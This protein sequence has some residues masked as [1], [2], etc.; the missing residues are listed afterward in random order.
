MIDEKIGKSEFEFTS[1]FFVEKVWNGTKYHP[2]H[3]AVEDYYVKSLKKTVTDEVHKVIMKEAG[4]LL[5]VIIKGVF[6]MRAN[7]CFVQ[8]K[9]NVG[10]NRHMTSK[11]TKL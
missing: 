11:Y 8:T 1:S 5:G 7:E 3:Q 6:I 10:G 2:L 4:K 9:V